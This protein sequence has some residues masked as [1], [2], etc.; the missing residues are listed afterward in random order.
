MIVSES[1]IQRFHSYYLNQ[2]QLDKT[3]LNGYLN[4]MPYSDFIFFVKTDTEI[5]KSRLQLNFSEKKEKF[6]LNNF[7]KLEKKMN[8]VYDHV[9][10]KKNVHLIFKED[11]LKK[12]I[13]QKF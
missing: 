3:A 10:K 6:Y 13:S 7:E 9:I 2:D 8:I 5:L 11:T 4:F 12:I 1:F